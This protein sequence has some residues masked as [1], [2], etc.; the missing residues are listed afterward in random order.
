MTLEYSVNL[1]W[2]SCRCLQCEAQLVTY[3]AKSSIV[4]QPTL[5]IPIPTEMFV[6]PAG[7]TGVVKLAWVQEDVAA[8]LADCAQ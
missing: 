2:P 8:S 3:S 4:T 1:G 6:A 5:A 7:T